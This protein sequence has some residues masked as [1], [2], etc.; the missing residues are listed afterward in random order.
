MRVYSLYRSAQ[1]PY[2]C[3]HEEQHGEKPT[4][5]GGNQTLKGGAYRHPI[6][7]QNLSIPSHGTLVRPVLIHD[8]VSAPNGD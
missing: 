3:A 1:Y 8:D 5:M 6:G 4:Y 7:P 2:A